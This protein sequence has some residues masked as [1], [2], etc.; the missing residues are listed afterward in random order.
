M[1]S[2]KIGIGYEWWKK[3]SAIGKTDICTIGQ[4][5]KIQERDGLKSQPGLK[6][7][8]LEM[9]LYFT[10]VDRV[11]VVYVSILTD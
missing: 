7:W 4:S 2:L 1:T 10:L 9:E 11:E 3:K 5:L 6:Q 8:S